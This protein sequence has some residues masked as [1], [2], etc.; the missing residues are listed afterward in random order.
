MAMVAIARP[1]VGVCIS[2]S[3]VRTVSVGVS[4]MLVSV[5]TMRLAVTAAV[6]VMV[7]GVGV[8]RSLVGARA[9]MA[10]VATAVVVRVLVALPLCAVPLLAVPL[11]AVSLLAMSLL[12]ALL[13]AVA[14][15][16]PSLAQ[17]PPALV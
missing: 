1:V 3:S 14:R 8:I 16:E 2:P 5:D 17:P 6:F 10:P 12:A 9:L 7:M 4:A 13:M 11:L 15:P